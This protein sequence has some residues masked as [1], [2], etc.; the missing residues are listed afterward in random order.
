MLA[1]ALP[2][3]LAQGAVDEFTSWRR[4]KSGPGRTAESVLVQMEAHERGSQ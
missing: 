1:P 4:G 2:I 3:G